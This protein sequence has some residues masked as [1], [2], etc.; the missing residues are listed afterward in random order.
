MMR[1]H[2]NFIS[3]FIGLIWFFFWFD[4]FVCLFF[5]YVAAPKRNTMEPECN[6]KSGLS[7]MPITF[8]RGNSLNRSEKGDVKFD[9]YKPKL[10]E[11]FIA[12]SPKENWALCCVKLLAEL[13]TF[14]QFKD[15]IYRYRPLRGDSSAKSWQITVT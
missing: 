2:C 10:L 9:L 6:L 5:Q 11:Q 15:T 14:R 8:E 3:G 13:V 12:Q 4:L 7:E 1:K